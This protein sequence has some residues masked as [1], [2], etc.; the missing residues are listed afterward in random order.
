M[1]ESGEGVE[2]QPLGTVRG[3]F[4]DE[5]LGDDDGP[6]LRMWPLALPFQER[7]YFEYDA[8]HFTE[9][10]RVMILEDRAILMQNH[11]L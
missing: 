8:A 5:A 3:S 4:R 9:T 1:Q 2:M 11:A 10:M 6:E 7:V